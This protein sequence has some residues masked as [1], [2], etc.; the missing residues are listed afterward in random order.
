[1]RLIFIHGRD[2]QGQDRQALQ[3]VWSEALDV[4]LDAAGLPS[5]REHDVVF[6]YYADDLMAMVNQVRSAPPP[7]VISKGGAP[8]DASLDS[9]HIDLLR[10]IL[11]DDAADEAARAEFKHKGAQ[12]TTF[13]LALARLADQSGFGLDLLTRLTE[14]VSI[15]LQHDVVARRINDYVRLAIGQQPCVVVAHSLGS[16]VAYRVLREL[17]SEAQVRRLVT[18]GSPLGL[19]TVRKLLF[20][21]A[22]VF[23]AGAKSWF[24]AFDPTDIVALHPLDNKTWPISPTIEN[25][26]QVTNHTENHHGISGY[27]DN[28]EVARAI[29]EAL[30]QH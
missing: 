8:Q 28:P 4:G 12:N 14:D 23:P 21:P 18:L 19:R 1:M 25:Y 20:P 15:Y 29:Y 9:V 16:I 7:G 10:E 11:G 30:N 27:L 6:P 26:G 24:N 3:R 17:G 5:I 13:A 22:R 2:Q